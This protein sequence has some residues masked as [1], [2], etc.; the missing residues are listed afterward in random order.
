ME[1]RVRHRWSYEYA[2]VWPNSGVDPELHSTRMWR[3]THLYPN[4]DLLAIFDSQGL[5]KLNRDSELI[6]AKAISAHHDL[7][8][9]PNGDIYVLPRE[10]RLVP[11][12]HPTAPVIDDFVSVLDPSG[13]ERMRVSLLEALEN[14]DFVSLWRESGSYRWA[15]DGRGVDS[16]N[17][18]SRELFHTNTLAILDGSLAQRSPAFRAGNVLVSLLNMD[19]VAVVDLEKKSIVWAR[20]LGFAKQHDPSITDSGS[21]LLFDNRG[22]KERSRIWEWDPID[23]DL[24]WRYDGGEEG[25]FFSQC[26][27]TV[28]R[29]PN[30]NTLVTETDS[31]RAFELDSAERVVWEYRSPERALDDEKL[32]ARLF[33][34]RRL[35]S[36]FGEGW[37][38]TEKSTRAEARY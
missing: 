30:G 35:P 20:K 27:G 25:P 37:L 12:L 13:A 38:G 21:M 6:W 31:G 34:V 8:V 22:E 9:A 4:G 36:D 3:R 32:V 16:D 33:E 19:L 29:L 1:G 14:S 5:V 26:C 7:D 11:D 10:S 24:I 15:R 23:D 17:P 2:T 18:D 28:Q